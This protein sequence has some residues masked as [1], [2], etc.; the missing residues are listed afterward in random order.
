MKTDI[1]QLLKERILI[2]DG[3]M[4]TMLQENGLEPGMCPE[5]YGIENAQVLFEIHKQYV[6]AGS[7]IIQTN[8]F[9]GN[10][11]KLDEFGLGERVVEINTEAVRIAKQS[12]NNK[13]FVA[14]SIGPTGKLLKPVGEVEFN[15][16]Y[17]VY[18]EQAIACEKAGADLISIETMTDIGEM[19][20]ALIAIRSNT[21]L[22]VLAHMT[23][24]D[25]ERTMMGTDPVTAL[26]ILEALSPLAIGANC[27]GGAKELLP[28]IS[29]MANYTSGYLSVEPNA[30][31]PRLIDDKTIFPDSPEEMA[32]Y[33]IRL[34]DA[35][36]NIIGG[37]CGS[38]PTHVKAM[39][40]AV[41]G[42]SP[43]KHTSKK[44]FAFASRS[45][46]LI[47]G[48]DKP[49]AFIGERINPTARKNLAQ[50]IKDG[51]MQM[52]IEEAKKQVQVGTPILDV[53][54]G[55]PGIDE[56]E[57]MKKAIMSIQSAIDV[58]LVID[59]TN[60]N[61]VEEG[62]KNFIGRPLINST[63]GEEKALS[64]LLPIA[65]KYGAAILGLCLDETGIP[66]KAEDRVKIAGKIYQRAKEYGLRDEDIYIDCLVKTAS[67]EQTQVM[68]TI[69]ALQSIKENLNVR[70]VLGISNVSHGLP[71][72]DILN[73]TYLSMAW[74]GGV[75]L[76]I[77]NPFDQKMME[78]TRAAAV[79]LN[80]DTNATQYIENYK[81][82]QPSD[83]IGL[84][85]TIC[86]KCNLPDIISENKAEQKEVKI[87]D[88]KNTIVENNVKN[89]LSKAILEGN[90]DNIQSLV[91]NAV[92]KENIPALEV[93]NQALIPGIEKAGELYD[94]KQ[95]FLPQL[96]MAAESMKKAFAVIKSYF[97]DSD[98]S[99]Q[100]VIVM[101][102][103]EGDIHDIGK[104]IVCVLLENY[105]FKIIDLGKDVPAETILQRAE[106]E[107]ADI[108]G[109]SALMTTTMPRMKEII[110]GVKEK[111]LN[112]RVMVGGAVL[113]QEYADKIGADAYSEDARQA[114]I[115]AQRLL[116][117]SSIIEGENKL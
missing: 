22:P 83:N 37:C 32:E 53:N 18:K 46:H 114:V 17:N 57:A 59:S 110:E 20:A 107:K 54:M 14:A 55:V 28:I 12:A 85:H 8:T 64:E 19:R 52:V 90:V 76:P 50:D 94:K 93:V 48:D 49:L 71:A 81:E 43:R 5:L 97:D 11:Y 61:A 104:N 99:N 75:D 42:L 89:N 13:A 45:Q 117:L 96:M 35:G 23:F 105:G 103:V 112:C 108:I 21:S 7:D 36:A 33:A 70:T 15:D 6:E 3:A 34:S 106:E 4:G 86:E 102:T 1:Q 116:G 27:S 68:E 79:L 10:R 80:R 47:I 2:L 30:G 109:L 66:D 77:I 73:S 31:L 65:K 26:I 95:Y 113:N 111:Q 56:A 84:R 29:T 87:T 62:L 69:K 91:I 38:T 60:L 72:R 78:A 98:T 9:G 92:E 41:K 67:A 58:P 24:E 51:K 39:S 25:G 82:Y 88:D 16:L 74:Y 115:T 44:L 101:A 63:T 40:N 100:G